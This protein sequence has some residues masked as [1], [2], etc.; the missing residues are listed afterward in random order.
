MTFSHETGAGGQ[1]PHPLKHLR[2]PLPAAA[3]HAQNSNLCL[4][5]HLPQQPTVVMALASLLLRWVAHP[6]L[7]LR[8]FMAV[9]QLLHHPPTAA[10]FC[11]NPTQQH[12]LRH[13]RSLQRQTMP[14]INSNST[15]ATTRHAPRHV[16][17]GVAVATATI[18]VARPATATQEMVMPTIPLMHSRVGQPSERAHE[19]T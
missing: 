8:L 2:L 7:I 5:A 10:M 17:T 9:D 13:H 12:L 1:S 6:L 18:R 19:Q 3:K 4:E 14:C 15:K 11:Q 16:S